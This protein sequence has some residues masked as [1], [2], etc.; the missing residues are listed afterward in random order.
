MTLWTR[1][2]ATLLAAGVPLDRALGFGAAHLGH[3][4]L[5]GALREVR[6]AVRNGSALAEAL[7]RH[8]RYFDAL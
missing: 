4:G 2:T 1:S 6:R 3:A 7:G 5:E 8:G